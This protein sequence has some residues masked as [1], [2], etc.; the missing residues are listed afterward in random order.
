ME[1]NLDYNNA[2]DKYLLVPLDK[3]HLAGE[4][5]FEKGEIKVFLGDNPVCVNLLDF[6][7]KQHQE[8]PSAYNIFDQYDIW[9]ITYSVSII[10]YGSW[11]R[12]KQIG[13]EITYPH[14]EDDPKIIVIHNM[15]ETFFKK[16][17]TGGLVFNAGI[18][19]NGQV[20]IAADSIPILDQIDLGFSGKLN[21]VGNAS[22]GFNINFTVLSTKIISI[23]VGDYHSEW[24]MRPDDSPLLGDQLFT[25]TILTPKGLLNLSATATVSATITGPMGSFPVK[26]KSKSRLLSLW[27]N[28]NSQ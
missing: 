3:A 14:D 28:S 25:Q 18:E 8:I 15:P 27:S 23:G 2:V 26:M 19:L 1:I 10:K 12:I 5:E 20:N 7:L 13:L 21:L 16:I 6:Y 9:L 22:F 24:L 17:G 11:D 4:P